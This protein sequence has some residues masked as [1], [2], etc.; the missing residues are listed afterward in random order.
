MLG[1][2]V[3]VIEVKSAIKLDDVC[4]GIYCN[5]SQDCTD[6]PHLATA[7]YMDLDMTCVVAPPAHYD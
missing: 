1:M 7:L 6:D 2:Q 3:E 4:P 5:Y